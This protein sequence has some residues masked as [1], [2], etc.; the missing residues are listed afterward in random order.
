MLRDKMLRDKKGPVPW[1]WPSSLHPAIRFD[2]PL[3]PSCRHGVRWRGAPGLKAV[4]GTPIC[5]QQMGQ[6][7]A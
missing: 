5:E 2:L 4:A 3:S 6:M 7:G 1:F